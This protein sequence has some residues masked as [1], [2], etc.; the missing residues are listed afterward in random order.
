MELNGLEHDEQHL[1]TDTTTSHPLPHGFDQRSQDDLFSKYVQEDSARMGRLWKQTMH[2]QFQKGNG[3]RSVAA[4][5]VRW[6]DEHD[7][8]LKCAQEVGG[9]C[10]ALYT[11]EADP[12][13]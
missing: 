9:V 8:D 11:S 10:C 2:Q 12:R 5:L 1:H 4:L 7:R 13:T 3:Y 6:N